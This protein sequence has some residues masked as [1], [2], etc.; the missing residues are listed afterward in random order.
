MT[1]A[2]VETHRPNPADDFKVPAS[3]AARLEGLRRTGG[4]GGGGGDTSDHGPQLAEDPQDRR[5][6]VAQTAWANS[7]KAAHFE[8][9]AH[10]TIDALAADQHPAHLRGYVE[11]LG[12]GAKVLNLVLGGRVGPGKTSAAIAA[13]NAAVGRGLITRVVRHAD[14]L[15][16]L[17]PEGSP[18]ELQS[19]QIEARYRDCDLLILDD[20]GAGLDPNQPASEFKRTQTLS[21][22]GDRINSGKATII[23]TNEQ[24]DVVRDGETVGGLALMFGPQVISR[25]SERGHA[26]RF[27]GPDRRGRLSW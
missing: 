27:A 16:W 7:L 4:T 22:I 18:K 14:Y 8:E 24:A 10:W 20:M 5:R 13:G 19:W 25:I 17:T 21:L 11:S 1:A 2:T 6:Q 15:K 9:L 23:T 26:V 12:K 3:L